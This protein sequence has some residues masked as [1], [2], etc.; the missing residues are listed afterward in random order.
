MSAP[1]TATMTAAPATTPAA[2]Y[3]NLIK[4]ISTDAT[5]E[6]AK[7]DNLSTKAVT[8]TVD[9]INY[10]IKFKEQNTLTE[11]VKKLT[12]PDKKYYI[13]LLKKQ[14]FITV[15]AL[16]LKSLQDT[17]MPLFD[18]NIC[19]TDSTVNATNKNTIIKD[20]LCKV[21]N[22][23]IHDLFASNNRIQ[24]SVNNQSNYA[25]QEQYYKNA[26][27]LI[28]TLRSQRNL[29]RGNKDANDQ[30]DKLKEQRKK[31]ELILYKHYET[32]YTNLGDVNKI[33][34]A[35]K[36]AER[37]SV[38]DIDTKALI[39]L[40]KTWYGKI[41]ADHSKYRT[42]FYN[43][44]KQYGSWKQTVTPGRFR[45]GE[46]KTRRSKTNDKRKTRKI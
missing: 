19:G 15:K 20:T 45:G 30:I 44:Y 17:Q 14:I 2:A 13:Q 43:K 7:L 8:I 31:L 36:N 35:I 9:G 41:K 28:E 42:E 37:L 4:A 11:P 40:I 25:V 16:L 12:E 21:I 5:T 27:I 26:N 10:E 34:D 3:S 6:L 38:N 1:T 29:L 46:N 24:N 33:D 22:P 39:D 18:K 23:I 32:L